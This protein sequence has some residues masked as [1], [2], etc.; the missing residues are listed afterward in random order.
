MNIMLEQMSRMPTLLFN[1][2]IQHGTRE[3]VRGGGNTAANYVGILN[4]F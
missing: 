3:Y 4:E 2:I 1:N